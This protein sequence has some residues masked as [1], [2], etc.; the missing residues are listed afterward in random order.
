M[1]TNSSHLGA[2]RELAPSKQESTTY[3]PSLV[4]KLLIL[5]CR[6]LIPDRL[7]V[8]AF[9]AGIVLLG[10][11]GCSSRPN[12]FTE[13][14]DER[15]RR[16]NEERTRL[17]T[18]TNPVAR[19][20]VQ[21]RI[22]DLLISFVGDAVDL[23]DV[24]LI[25]ERVREYTE[26]IVDARDTMVNSGRNAVNDASG[27]RELEI[28]LRQHIRQVGDIGAQL[29]FERRQVL[30]QLITQISDIREEMLDMLFPEQDAI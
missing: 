10:L 29:N 5:G 22:S 20:R 25:D 28:A 4:C 8:K 23:G 27:Y 21:I 13:S 9:F 2:C 1:K 12:V 30:D 18:T 15:L 17:E 3:E 6:P 16:L 14:L 26:T 19:T 11:I 7:L 24:E